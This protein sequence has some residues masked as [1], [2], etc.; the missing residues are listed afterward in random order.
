[1][2]L[3]AKLL[4]QLSPPLAAVPTWQALPADIQ[5]V[6]VTRMSV[7]TLCSFACTSKN[8][9]RLIQASPL[10]ERLLN[11][12]S[13]GTT[14]RADLSSAASPPYCMRRVTKIICDQLRQYPWAPSL[15]QGLHQ[16]DLSQGDLSRIFARAQREENL[17]TVATRWVR[18]TLNG[19]RHSLETAR[20]MAVPPPVRQQA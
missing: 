8:S 12:V 15:A 4:S 7:A 18:S 5:H 9:R 11:S 16:P 13:H 19:S 14:S 17:R 10:W 2:P 3:G 20:T 1:M 6:V